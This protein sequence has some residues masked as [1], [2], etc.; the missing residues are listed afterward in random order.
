MEIWKPVTEPQVSGSGLSASR[1]VKPGDQHR[2]LWLIAEE[3]VV[4]SLNNVRNKE[5]GDHLHPIL[6]RDK[7]DQEKTEYTKKGSISNEVFFF[8]FFF[9]S[10]PGRSRQ[11][12]LCVLELYNHVRGRSHLFCVAYILKRVFTVFWE[13]LYGS[14]S[15]PVRLFCVRLYDATRKCNTGTVFVLEPEFHSSSKSKS[16]NSIV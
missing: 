16:R 5:K 1:E 12:S 7:S 13:L 15:I 4:L 2:V 8:F 6:S 10:F 14:E 3:C 9:F 11:V